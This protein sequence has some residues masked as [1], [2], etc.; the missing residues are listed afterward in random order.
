M[1]VCIF[2]FGLILIFVV[3]E[4][5]KLPSAQTGILEQR[6]K[7]MKKLFQYMC[8]CFIAAVISL[9]VLS[10][11]SAVYFNPPIATQQPDGITNFKY[12]PDSKWSYMLEGF[13]KGKTDDTGYNNAYYSD[14]S[15]PDIVFA[16]SSHLE[17]LQVP[18][19]ANCVYLLNE[20]FD[21][22]NVDTNNF[23]CFNLGM[24]GHFFEATSSNYEYIAKKFNGAKYVVI[25]MFD[26]KYSPDVLDQII[27]NEFHEPMEKKGFV[28]E[29]LQKFPFFRLMYK[30]INETTS[31][32]NVPVS[33]DGSSSVNK[34]FEMNVYVEKMNTI[35]A[36]ITKISEEN[37]I[38]P[39]ILMHER[40][41]VNEEGNI[42]MEMDESYKEAF[43]M[44]CET[45]GL[46]VIDVSSNMVDEYEEKHLF[47]Y[48]FSNSAPGEGHLN[49]TGHRI[50]AET[51]YKYINEMEEL[52]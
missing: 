21:K 49:Q 24:S 39:I 40:F 1:S 28:Y 8:K 9:I 12:I 18:E 22:D 7:I 38:V 45:N 42:I 6:S 46:N 26:A 41:W 10:L 5:N 47:S 23:K 34:E 29:T 30:K 43:K 17:A 2:F 14:C 50:V 33:A 13:G 36:E 51:V 16:G 32:K 31:V 48:G 3:F 20:M 37:N 25:E 15:N 52:R 19:N 35:L 44:C 4:H 11:F 27:E